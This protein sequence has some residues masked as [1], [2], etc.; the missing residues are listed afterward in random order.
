MRIENQEQ[1]LRTFED[2]P[3]IFSRTCD[4][5]ESHPE[6]CHLRTHVEGLVKVL[7]EIFQSLWLSYHAGTK[8][9]VNAALSPKDIMT[10]ES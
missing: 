7:V 6:D 9:P 4:V 5:I 10:N 2:L 1:I 8:G 3:I